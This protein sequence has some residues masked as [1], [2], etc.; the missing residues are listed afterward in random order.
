[1]KK[2]KYYKIKNNP[3]TEKDDK[4]CKL[5]FTVDENCEIVKNK[6]VKTTILMRN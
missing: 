2:K 6:N 1:M 5:H 4:N 3:F